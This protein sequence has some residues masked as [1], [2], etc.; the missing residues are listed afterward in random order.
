MKS[1]AGVQTK[2]AQIRGKGDVLGHIPISMEVGVLP[3][4]Q[5]PV[6]YILDALKTNIFVFRLV[7]QKLLSSLP[8]QQF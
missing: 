6:E 1:S 8:L 2:I 7:F 4:E 3:Q 5:F